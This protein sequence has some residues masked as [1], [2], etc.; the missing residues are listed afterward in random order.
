MDRKERQ[1]T[2]DQAPLLSI[3]HCARCSKSC[4]IRGP[5]L[6]AVDHPLVMLTPA[7]GPRGLCEECAAHWWLFSVDGLRWTLQESGPELLCLD[8]VQ[9]ELWRVLGMMHPALGRLDWG[10]LIAQ[11]DLPWP[12]DWKLPKDGINA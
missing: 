4:L 3:A 9:A 6:P 11:W 1:T 7:K 8:N 2:R 10:R 5:S 12:D